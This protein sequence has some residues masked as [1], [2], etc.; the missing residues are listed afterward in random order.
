MR[1]RTYLGVVGMAALS[2]CSAL[3][4]GGPVDEVG[5]SFRTDDEI[6]ITVDQLETQAGGSVTLGEN[7]PIS[8]A[9]SSI[10]FVLPH[11]VATNTTES[12][13]SVPDVS[14]F[15][16]LSNGVRE[17]PY[18]ID[19]RGIMDST[20]STIS[21]PVSGPLFP[22][23]TELGPGEE[24]EGWLVFTVPDAGETVLL[25]LRLGDDVAFDWSLAVS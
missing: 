7:S 3:T 16:L 23:T 21:Q 11:L 24:T 1:R 14:S 22:A 20:E 5:E 6:E 19:Y 12:T 10:A 8:S 15:G 13:V 9:S 17:D 2:G 4:G 25:E 18:R